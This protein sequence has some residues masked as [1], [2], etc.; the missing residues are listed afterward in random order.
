MSKRKLERKVTDPDRPIVIR[1]TSGDP[2]A[3]AHCAIFSTLVKVL[4]RDRCEYFLFVKGTRMQAC[5]Y[6]PNKRVVM[7]IEQD[8]DFDNPD[9]EA[10]YVAVLLN[11]NDVRDKIPKGATNKRGLMRILEIVAE[12]VDAASL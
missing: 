6:T 9:S 8:K 3:T 10:S 7:R 11:G 1:G 12:A 5:V 2:L 4:L